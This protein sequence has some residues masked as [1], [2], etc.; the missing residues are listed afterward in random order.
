MRLIPEKN[1]IVFNVSRPERLLTAIPTAKPLPPN[2]GYTVAVPYNLDETKLLNNLGISTPSP[3]LHQYDWPGQFEPFEAQRE[4]AAML[5]LNSR[6][7]VLNEVGCVGAD[8]EYLS[9]TGWVRIADYAGGQVAQ[10]HPES[11]VAEF[12]TPTEYVKLPCEQM[13]RIKTKH[14]IDQLLSPEHRV[15]LQSKNNPDKREVV[16]AA[17]L[18][19]QRSR[20][21]GKRVPGQIAF[22]QAAIPNTFTID[23]PGISLTDEQI[24][25]MVAIHAD[26]HFDGNTNRC[27]IRLKREWKKARLRK[28][29]QDAGIEFTVKPCSPFDGFEKFVFQAPVRSKDYSDWWGASDAQRRVIADEVLHWGGTTEKDSFSSFNREDA[30]FIQYVFVSTGRTARML[31]NVRERRGRTEVEYVVQIRKTGKPLGIAGKNK[32]GEVLT[33]MSVEPSPDG[34]K[35]CFMVPSTFLVL[36]RNGCVFLSGNTGKSM[37]VLWA[38]DYLRSVGAAKKLLVSA[39]LSTLERTWADEI[40]IH[41]P[42][43]NFS[44]L[45]GSRTQRRKALKVDA[46]VYIINHDGVKVILDEL[47]A[48]KDITH[49]AIDELAIL[50]N[51]RTDKWKAH[52]TLVNKSSTYRACWGMTGT[53]TP[54]QPTDAWA[55]V[56]LITPESA[57]RSFM[58]FR[59]MTMRQAGPYKWVPRHNAM[60]T[61]KNIM[62]PAVRFTRDECMDLPDCMYESRKVQM[63]KEQAK[64]YKMMATQLVAQVEQGQILAVNEAVKVNKLVQIACGVAYSTEGEE[65]EI[66]ATPRLEELV[67]VTEA[68]PHKVIVFVP[69]V[70]TISTVKAYIQKKGYTAE[71]VYGEVS[72]AERDRIFYEFQ[73]TDNP[74]VLVAQPAAMSHGLTLTSANTIVWY[75]PVM[76]NDIYEQANGRITRP[77]QKNKQYIVHLEGTPIEA[78][79][80]K[81]LKE[82]QTLQGVLLDAVKNDRLFA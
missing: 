17:E 79:I 34:F 72:K 23:T 15:L 39:P 43:L 69:Y 59:D 24:R 38:Y 18:F 16:Q 35:Y 42:H 13:I 80:Y 32:D 29:L 63:T 45:Y 37:S 58:K 8:T 44:V 56:K 36:R 61:V 60:E 66:D 65:V 9:P 10:Y 1:A 55:Q 57:P 67:S 12:V 6:A 20:E 7:F 49:V 73:K 74:K 47:M 31:T 76:S 30:D 14:G 77:G 52:N 3:I 75:G 11:G 2:L 51:A 46:D 64:A 40:F 33:N 27:V 5:T 22:S 28:L 25:V 71:A 26:G 50:R 53:P 70:S 21:P 4:T 54:N 82:K 81:R 19:F 41:L 48:R 78:R 68:T 62:Q